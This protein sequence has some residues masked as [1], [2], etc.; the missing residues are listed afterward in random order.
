MTG[1]TGERTEQAT[2]K[3]FQISKMVAWETLPRGKANNGAAEVDE[4]SIESPVAAPPT[5]PPR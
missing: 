5:T 1:R 2:G 4:Q 3:P